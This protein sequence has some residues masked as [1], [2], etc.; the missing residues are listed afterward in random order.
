MTSSAA[1]AEHL[2]RWLQAKRDFPGLDVGEEPKPE[3]SGLIAG[4]VRMGFMDHPRKAI[5]RDFE[6]TF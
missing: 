4:F 6:R 1:Y 3:L 5:I 2:T